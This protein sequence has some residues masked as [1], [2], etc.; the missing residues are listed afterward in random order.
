MNIYWVA[1]LMGLMGSV[2]CVAMCGPILLA[3]PYNNTSRWVN[4]F[5]NLIYHFG[6]IMVYVILGILIVL[7]GKTGGL[8]IDHQKVSLWIGIIMVSLSIYALFGFRFKKYDSFYKKVI[9]LFSKVFGKFYQSRFFPLLAG[10]LN[11]I[12]PCGMVYVALGVSANANSIM[13]GSKFMM[14]FG[15]G[16]VPLLLILSVGGVFI[17]KYIK[18]NPK[19]WVPVFGIF[20]GILFITRA[21]EL[22]LP[23]ISPIILNSIDA[24]CK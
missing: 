11:G 4:F 19:T 1:T 23:F 20:F 24:F 13:E 8:F 17:K 7:V 18:F 22:D 14:F 9:N 21:L 3:I 16:T 10:M 15:L 12:L 6:R 5:K 2:H